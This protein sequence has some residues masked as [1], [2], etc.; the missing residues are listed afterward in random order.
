MD[1]PWLR[2]RGHADA[3]A[4]GAGLILK[5]SLRTGAPGRH[6]GPTFRRRAG[7]LRTALLCAP[8]LALLFVPSPCRAVDPTYLSQLIERAHRLRLAERPGWRA[9]LYYKPLP[10]SR[11]VESEVDSD[12]FFLSPE[13][14]RDPQAELDA[15]LAA[16]FKADGDPE[17]CAQCTFAARYHWLKTMLKFDPGRLPERPCRRFPPW[18]KNLPPCGIT[19]VS[20]PAA[21]NNPA[22]M[23]G[24]TFLRIDACGQ[25][26]QTRLLAST[27]NYAAQSKREHGI[28]FAFKGL[29]GLYHGHFSVAPFYL[30][31]KKYGDI[32]NRDIWEYR[33]N[34]SRDEIDQ[35]LRH[36]WEMRFAWFDYYFLDENCSY[37]LLSLLDVAR[38]GLHLTGRFSWWAIPSETV[39]AVDKA[40]LVREVKFR[41]ARNTIL[42]KRASLMDAARQ[43]LAMRL[44]RGELGADSQEMKRLAPADRPSVIERA[45][46]YAASLQIPRAGDLPETPATVSQMLKAR[47]RLDAPDQTP[48]IP[49]PE[50]A[51]GRGHKPARAGI[52]YGVEDHRQ[53]I[54]IA[55]APAYHDLFDPPG[56][57]TPGRVDVTRSAPAS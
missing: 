34:L 33:L 50:V 14:K 47:S 45:L 5:P 53:F 31:V 11:G 4:R 37:H 57:Y 17:K 56:G 28:E 27:V 15:T 35:L 32:E 22:S 1:F 39:R 16:F 54:E 44:A 21:L 29:F 48:T 40:G 49:A 41:P 51:P 30:M 6:S 13:G 46:D 26:E 25:D 42:R 18:M 38:P 9:L 55:G 2:W 23:F 10:F 24:H 20:P 36:V 3:E 52:G 19:P 8:F 12:S 43:G 7:Q